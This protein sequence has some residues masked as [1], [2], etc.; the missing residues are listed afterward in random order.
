MYILRTI[1]DKYVLTWSKANN[2]YF[3]DL[4]ATLGTVGLMGYYWNFRKAE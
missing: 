1:V 3:I 2:A 4:K